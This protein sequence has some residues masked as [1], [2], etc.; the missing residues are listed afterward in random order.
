M[1]YR[2]IVTRKKANGLW[3]INFLNCPRQPQCDGKMLLGIAI[4]SYRYPGERSCFYVHRL[5]TNDDLVL[6]DV[7]KCN[8]C[9]HSELIKKGYYYESE[10]INKNKEV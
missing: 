5:I 4:E 6:I 1:V 3:K 2:K 7:L 8:K 9:G 10:A